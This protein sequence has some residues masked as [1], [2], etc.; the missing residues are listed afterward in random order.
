[1]VKL[2][3]YIELTKD[4]IKYL[5]LSVPR[6][7]ANRSRPGSLCYLT[8]TYMLLVPKEYQVLNWIGL[9]THISFINDKLMFIGNHGELRE[10]NLD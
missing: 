10:I 6:E 7:I 4:G 1:L 3:I 9:L 2:N 8:S 5:A